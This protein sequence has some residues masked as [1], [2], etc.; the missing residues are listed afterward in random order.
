[1]AISRRKFLAAAGAAAILGPRALGA[2]EEERAT[3]LVMELREAF[4]DGQPGVEEALRRITSDPKGVIANLGEPTRGGITKL[5]NDTQITILQ[6]VWAPLMV[7]RPHDHNMWVSIGVYGGREDNIFWERTGDAIK[8]AGAD[9]FGVGDVG[10]LP[11]DGVHSVVNPIQQLTAAIHVYGG[12]FFAP[13]RT[14][15]AGENHDPNEFSQQG[16]LQHFENSNRR[17]NL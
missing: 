3:P 1:M 16:L 11:D 10:S 4:K 14:S 17:F 6:I 8:P 13:G 12:D 15:W 7:L 5:Y 9:S 2:A